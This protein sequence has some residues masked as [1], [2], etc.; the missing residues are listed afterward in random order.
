MTIFAPRFSQESLAHK[1]TPLRSPRP[2]PTPCAPGPPLVQRKPACACGG[3]CPRCQATTSNP[4]T[5]N[6]KIGE[7]DDPYEREAD[8]VAE[9]VMRLSDAEVRRS[10]AGPLLQRACVGCEEGEGEEEEEG[11]LLQAK[12]APSSPEQPEGDVPKAPPA[13]GEVIASPGQPLDAELRAFFEPRFSCDFSRVRVHLGPTAEQSARAVNAHAYTVGQDIVF[14]AG[15]FAPNTPQGR[16]LLA[17]ELTHVVQQSQG[18]LALQREEGEGVPEM[19]RAEEIRLSL[20][21]PG[22]AAAQPAPPALSLFNFGIDRYQ[23]KEFHQ[24]V[25]AE[26]ARFVRTEIPFPTRLRVVGHASAPGTV[27]HNQAL[28]LRRAQA[29]AAVLTRGGLTGIQILASGESAPVASNDD[30]EGR[31]RNRR[32]DLMLSLA[33]RPGGTPEPEPP[34]PEPPEPEPPEPE[35]PEPEPPE[36]PEPPRPPEEEGFCRRYPLLC[37]LVPPII[38]IPIPIPLPP[39]LPLLC[40]IAPELCIVAPCIVNPSLCVPEPPGPPQPPEPE[41]PPEEPEEQPTVIFGPVRASNTPAAMQDRIPDQGSTAVPVFV[42]GLQASMGSI[43]VRPLGAGPRNG[44]FLIDG[45]RDTT[46]TG[47]TILDISGSSQTSPAARDFNL[48]LEALLGT[49]VLGRSSPFAVSALMENMSTRLDEVEDVPEGI[50]LG[51]MMSKESDGANGIRSLNEMEY[52]EELDILSETGGMVG[53]GLG[54]HG[55]LALANIDQTDYHGT[56]RSYLR[57]EGRQELIQVHTFLDHR[58]GSENIP[59]TNSG[60]GVTRSVEPDPEREGCLRFVVSKFGMA[61]TAAGFRSGAGAGRAEAVVPLPCP[62]GPGGG[63][64]GRRP[65]GGGGSTPSTPTIPTPHL[66]PLPSGATP[67][68]YAGGLSPG[69]SVGALP[70]LVIAFAA[71]STDPRRPERRVFTSPIPCVVIDENPTHVVLRTLNPVPLSLAPS[72]FSLTVM[73]ARKRIAVP[74]SL[75]R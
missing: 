57:R 7:P 6:L 53:F 62:P 69:I 29:V 27:A 48:Q 15:R 30:P 34:E 38:P 8:A 4:T 2:S 16:Q 51:A 49:A 23:P 55:F 26:F 13:V 73:P 68:S 58:T 28:S 40:V 60:F 56:P 43:L 54:E 70:I 14:G 12:A 47:S 50:T 35:P 42:S 59:V 1:P 17:H 65:G 46:I 21:S 32:V 11:M 24:A 22:R 44:D 52:G 67:F 25:L 75:I 10:P 61:G 71:I 36:P 19:S 5:S 37:D 41:R 20:S 18:S 63:G 3:G 39:L 64:T 33:A 9:R 72:G 66:G 74:R 45:S 31:S